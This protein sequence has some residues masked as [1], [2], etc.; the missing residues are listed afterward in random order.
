MN[1][2]PPHFLVPERA[3]ELYRA[4]G[5][6]LAAKERADFPMLCVKTGLPADC[7]VAFRYAW[8]EQLGIRFIILFLALWL[9]FFNFY[10]S[11]LLA[12]LFLTPIHLLF[13]TLGWRLK[14]PLSLQAWRGYQRRVLLF[15]IAFML[16][17]GLI[18]ISYFFYTIELRLIGAFCFVIL[19]ILCNA[20]CSPIKMLNMDGTFVFLSD[21]HPAFLATLPEL[22]AS[23]IFKAEPSDPA[24]GVWRL[25]N[26]L[27][28]RKGTPLPERCLLTNQSTARHLRIR[29]LWPSPAVVML[30]LFSVICL[31]F[32]GLILLALVLLTLKRVK[33]TL[34]FS[35]E[36]LRNR[37]RKILQW[38]AG[39]AL[40]SVILVPLMLL[41]E[42]LG[43]L[44]GLL[45]ALVA[46]YACPR[47]PVQVDRVQGEF[48]MIK[49]V[50]AEYLKSLPPF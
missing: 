40:A 46:A 20:H 12:V 5:Q 29:V 41:A 10:G 35:E 14:I 15:L 6:L 8:P 50:S 31:N 30:L 16:L 17:F 28:V 18:P 34:P 39:V 38:M 21:V 3:A 36:I 22:K 19:A 45:L 1:P 37:R 4:T 2:S 23:S 25:F 44:L 32:C 9:S 49:G 24:P 43:L 7:K 33:L 27:V 48:I 13:L 11:L 26:L 47:L 42:P